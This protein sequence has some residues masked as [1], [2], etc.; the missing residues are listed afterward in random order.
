[1]ECLLQCHSC[2]RVEY[3]ERIPFLTPLVHLLVSNNEGA[4]L[5]GFR[6]L[7]NTLHLLIDF[8]DADGSRHV[9]SIKALKNSCSWC[10]SSCI[11][12]T[13]FCFLF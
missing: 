13:D 6:A 5:Y 9:I 2:L 12:R 4:R 3:E 7:A 8:M 1:M 10:K 11:R